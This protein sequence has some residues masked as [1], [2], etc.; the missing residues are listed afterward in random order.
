MRVAQRREF[1]EGGID[2]LYIEDNKIIM[3]LGFT[4][5]NTA[6]KANE[7]LKRAGMKF[8]YIRYDDDLGEV[9]QITDVE[10]DWNE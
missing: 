9:Y 1:E 10:N 2:Q 3:S 6:E 5:L 8:R 4:D 7:I